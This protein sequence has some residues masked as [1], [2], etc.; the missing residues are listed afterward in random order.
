[1]TIWILLLIGAAS[2]VASCSTMHK[3]KSSRSSSL[4][5]LTNV[6][7]TETSVSKDQSVTAQQNDIQKTGS[8]K[9]TLIYDTGKVQIN[10]VRIP[11]GSEGKSA[12]DKVVNALVNERLR[13]VEIEGNLSLSDKSKTEVHNDKTDSTSKAENSQTHVKKT[14]EE[15]TLDK[16]V[17]GISIW[18]A[19]FGSLWFWLIVALLL[20]GVFIKYKPSIMKLL[21]KL[22]ILFVAIMIFSCNN[23]DGKVYPTDPVPTGWDHGVQTFTEYVV[24]KPTWEQSFYFAFKDGYTWQFV[25]GLLLIAIAIGVF[26]AIA[27]S[28]L[29]AKLVNLLLMVVLI[30]GGLGFIYA[31]PGTIKWNNNIKIEKQR[32][33]AARDDLPALWDQLY[34]EL[35]IV[36][37][38]GK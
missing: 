37:T 23:P 33:E 3:H 32:Y 20:I 2:T 30:A 6:V 36:G 15:K 9:L 10:T 7:A 17:K 8:V 5:S 24:I 34:E 18:A 14:E 31:R 38:S 21:K 1:M 28:L 12:L 29:K 22:R 26:Y 35:R 13:K 19:I 11:V 4:D 27:S 16:E 25:A